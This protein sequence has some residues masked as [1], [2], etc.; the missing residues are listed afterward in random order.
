MIGPRE[1]ITVLIGG[2]G[3]CRSTPLVKRLHF[4]GIPEWY[5]HGGPSQVGHH[6]AIA[7]DCLTST[8]V[9]CFIQADGT[10]ADCYRNTIG[11]PLRAFWARPNSHPLQ[12]PRGPPRM[13]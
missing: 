4:G 2:R 5:Q 9:F 13:S 3:L 7:P 1:I 10:V 8:R 6:F 12:L 11:G